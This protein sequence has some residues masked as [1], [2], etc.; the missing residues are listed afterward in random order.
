MGPALLLASA[1][2]ATLAAL[3]LP[4]LVTATLL[5]L[6]ARERRSR[7]LAATRELRAFAATLQDGL[8]VAP[9]DRSLLER[10]VTGAVN[11]HDARITFVRRGSGKHAHTA[12]VYDVQVHHPAASFEVA[13]T[14][15]LEALGRWL[16]LRKLDALG[17]EDLVLREGGES[18]GQL[19]QAKD[20]RAALRRVL[21]LTGVQSVTLQGRTL[22]IEQ[23]AEVHARS[24]QSAVRA[25]AQ[26]ARLCG[27]VPVSSL[28]VVVQERGAASVDLSTRFAWTGGG[29]AARCPYC[30]DELD[31][32]APEVAACERCGTVHHR[33]CLAEAGG[34][35]VFGCGAAERERAR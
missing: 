16:G 19:L 23:C 3:A 21:D 1:D 10:S 28:R 25:L 2:L 14:E 7:Y 32:A 17:Q 8:V 20:V 30:R 22:R 24:M 13:E 4:G 12:I 34:C 27:R 26:L 9:T 15:G 35:T 31:A 33:E 29:E 18:A 11:G 6:V 5:V